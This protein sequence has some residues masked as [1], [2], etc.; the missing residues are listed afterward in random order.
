MAT[1]SRKTTSDLRRFQRPGT[2]PASVVPPSSCLVAV[3][4]SLPISHLPT[5]P[6]P[7]P[8]PP[9]LPLRHYIP[10]FWS[11][12]FSVLICRRR[13]GP[14]PSLHPSPSPSLRPSPS[15]SLHPSISACLSLRVLL[16]IIPSP[17]PSSV[18]PEF[19]PLHQFAPTVNCVENNPAHRA[20]P[21]WV[22][23]QT[24]RT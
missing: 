24:D 12:L 14:L 5:S 13:R 11:C 15:P 18:T 3:S 4:V 2:S 17:S 8:P 6:N 22:G 21:S 10:F 9:L 23:L 7:S 16:L 20:P 19:I 1:R